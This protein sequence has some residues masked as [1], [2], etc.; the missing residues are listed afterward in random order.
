MIYPQK[1]N[2]RHAIFSPY[3]ALTLSIV[4]LFGAALYHGSV[5]I[6]S[7]AICEILNPLTHHHDEQPAR[8]ETW[9]YI[10]LHSR[11]PCAITA[12]LTGAAISLCGLLLQSYFRNPLADPSILGISSGAHLGIALITLLP[13]CSAPDLTGSVIT[14]TLSSLPPALAAVAGAAAVLSLLILLSR[15][16]PPTSLLIV[17]LLISYLSGAIITI[18]NY[19]A[20]SESVHTLLLWGMGDFSGVSLQQIPLYS[21]LICTSII[22]SL[23]LIKP[24]NAWMLGEPYA[25]NLGIRL[26]LTKTLILAITGLL[27]AITTAFCGPI[28]FVGL[29]SPHIARLISHSDDH[30]HLLPL[31]TLTGAAVALLCLCLSTLP[32]GGRLLP[33]NAL[34]PVIGIPI[35]LY[36]IIKKR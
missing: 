22:A 14:V 25:K 8:W 24:L 12:L 34:T 4:T 6:P 23:W 30:R 10:I 31:T 17:G 36:V 16:M 2:S 33:V 11:I 13:L 27:T 28:S 32:P 9:R 35:I 19:Y 21:A 5:D 29:A 7:E 26:P 18:L 20:E 1:K 3:S 15:Q